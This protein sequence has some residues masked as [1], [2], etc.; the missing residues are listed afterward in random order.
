MV[1]NNLGIEKPKE[2]ENELESTSEQ[3]N[4]AL[5][6]DGEKVVDSSEV[7]VANVFHTSKIIPYDDKKR[8]P[9]LRTRCAFCRAFGLPFALGF[10]FAAGTQTVDLYRTPS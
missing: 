4:D 5:V 2:E 10:P 6:H 1:E 3:T 8:L 7:Q 9:E